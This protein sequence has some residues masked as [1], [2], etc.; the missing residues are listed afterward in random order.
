MI[1]KENNAKEGPRI[2]FRGGFSDRNGIRPVNQNMQLSDLDYNTRVSL[3]NRINYYLTEKITQDSS[4]QF[5]V[6]H[7]L[8]DCFHFQ[9]DYKSYYDFRSII[10]EYIEK[11]IM[12]EPFDVVFT[13]IEF[14]IQS[15]KY[16]FYNYNESF[17]VIIN[18]AFT[19]EY[20]GYRIV[21]H[22]IVPITDSGEISSINE[23]IDSDKEVSVHLE[24]ALSLL[25]DRNNPDYEN[26]IKE[27][28]SAVEAMCNLFANTNNATLS[29]VLEI[30]KKKKSIHPAL[31]QAFEKLYGYTCDAK[32]VRHSG[33]LGGSNST[34]EEA[35]FML[36]ACS[37]F[38]NYLKG[39]SSYK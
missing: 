5:F 32:G 25:S 10:E 17:E 33:D 9:V 21:N 26:S 12:E 6:K 13:L 15:L 14:I 4:Q 30:I 16:L 23:A 24:K 29:K 8:S 22:I 28:I 20:V 19:N 37:A 39:C 3:S 35:Q 31:L 38:V 2:S 18:T 36:V 1:T 7:L 27:S 11:P 34:F